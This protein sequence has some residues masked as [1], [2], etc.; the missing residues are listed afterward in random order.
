[1]RHT[2]SNGENACTSHSDPVEI[3]M[4]WLYLGQRTQSLFIIWK[5]DEVYLKLA[6]AQQKKRRR[7]R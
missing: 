4:T 7:V 2:Q 6:P 5:D 1:M 3:L